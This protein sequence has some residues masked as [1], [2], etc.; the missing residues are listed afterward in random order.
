MP[1][2][3]CHAFQTAMSVMGMSSAEVESALGLIAGIL[4]LGNISFAENGN[5]AAIADA[6]C[7]LFLFLLIIKWL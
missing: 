5:Y 4:H 2:T 7:E 3:G 6:G 1:L